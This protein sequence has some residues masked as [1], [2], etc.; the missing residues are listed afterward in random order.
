MAERKNRTNL[1]DDGVSQIAKWAHLKQLY[2]FE[3]ER[4]VKITDLNEISIAPEPIERQQVSTS[5]RVFSETTYN[6]L[7]T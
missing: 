2:H 1:D 5:L 4:L 7:L 3:S 6:A